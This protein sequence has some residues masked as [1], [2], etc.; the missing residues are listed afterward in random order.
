MGLQDVVRQLDEL[1][2]RMVVG[3]ADAP[4]TLEVLAAIESS[5]PS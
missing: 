3:G 2:V 5:L 1:S 4:E